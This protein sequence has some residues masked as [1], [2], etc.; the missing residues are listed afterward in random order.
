MRGTRAA[1][2]LLEIDELLPVVNDPGWAEKYRATLTV[3]RRP[4]RCA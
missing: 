2:A 1:L 4:V 3:Q